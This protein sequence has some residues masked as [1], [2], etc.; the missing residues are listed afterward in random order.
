[1]RTVEVRH[2]MALRAI[3]EEESFHRAARRLGYTQPAISQQLAAL[4]RIVGDKLV[5]RPP[6]RTPTGLTELGAL[7]LRHANVIAAQIAIAEADI[8]AFR[9][10]ESGTLSIGFLRGGAGLVPSLLS[11]F[12]R[13]RPEAEVELCDATSDKE[14]LRALGAGEVD[15]ALVDLPVPDGPFEAIELAS[16]PYV[17][18]VS[19]QSPLALSASPPTLE[20]IA[21]MP[22]L[23]FRSGRSL[24][25]VLGVL[26]HA[27]GV[28]TIALRSDDSSTL[29]AAAAGGLGIA[30]VPR[31]AFDASDGRT[32]AIEPV[33]PFPPRE[34]GLV[35]HKG[36]RLRPTAKAFVE[37]TLAAQAGG[38][39]RRRV[40]RPAISSVI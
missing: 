4:E 33:P 12:M 16:D 1:M 9:E 3:A 17:A 31:L 7:V 28:L 2:L 11:G 15:I 6:G 19:A 24:D 32:Q 37:T 39:T 40:S 13:S 22:L 30:L 25:R 18:V 35:W 29:Q 23:C 36:R 8:A 20:E 27:Q 5:E 10:G 21:T 26:R 38:A 34:I 14:L